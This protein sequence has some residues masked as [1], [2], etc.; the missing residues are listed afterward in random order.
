MLREEEEEEKMKTFLTRRGTFGGANREQADQQLLRSKVEPG[1]TNGDPWRV[2][3][4]MGEFVDGFESLADIEKSVTIFGSA[5]T[6]KDDRYYRLGEDLGRVFAKAGY[7]VITGGGPGLMEAASK[8]AHENGGL[9]VGL[10]IELPH[11]QGM[12]DYI[13]LGIEFRYFFVRKT[14]FVKYAQAF[15]A[16]P[17]G[18]G[19]L[20]ELF[21]AVTLVQTHKI[22]KFPIV[23]VGHEFWDDLVKWL[24]KRL[25]TEGMVSSEEVALIQVVDTA[26]EALY[27]VKENSLQFP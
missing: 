20:D 6:A 5:R 8:G 21:E 3:R 15:V 19:T 13:D 27:V 14:M 12:N 9:A 11:E 4:I 7:T 17:G 26:E 1:W 23:L 24:K 16:L 22:Q 18:F 25:V 10:G 2:L